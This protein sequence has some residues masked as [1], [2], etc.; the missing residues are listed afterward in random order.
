MAG[1]ALDSGGVRCWGGNSS[2]QLGTGTTGPDQLV[3]V[4]V[5]GDEGERGLGHLLGCALGAESVG[6]FQ[7][8]SPKTPCA[9]RL[10][11]RILTFG[12]ARTGSVFAL[13][14]FIGTSRCVMRIPMCPTHTIGI[15]TDRLSGSGALP[16]D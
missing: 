7:I 4:A 8:V 15:R 9:S 10:V 1:S 2:G 13:A 16:P 11:A 12:A 6:T 14:Q 5:E 3:P